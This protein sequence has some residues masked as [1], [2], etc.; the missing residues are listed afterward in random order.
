MLEMFSSCQPRNPSHHRGWEEWLASEDQGKANR[1][2]SLLKTLSH[3]DGKMTMN[4]GLTF[5]R[6]NHSQFASNR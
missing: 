6:V 2:G 4:K 3:M 5:F 1:T